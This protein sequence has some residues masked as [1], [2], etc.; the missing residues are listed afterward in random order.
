MKLNENGDFC[1]LYIEPSDE[2]HQ[3]L[4]TIGEQQKPVVLML[5]AAGQPR[6][7]LFQRP[8]DFS[9]LK[10]V[11]RQS[12]VSIV[13]VTAGSDLL[14]QMAAR[15]GFPSYPTIDDFADFLIHGRRAQ[16]EED[17]AKFPPAL[18]RVRT[19]PLMPSTAIAQLAA[20]RQPLNTRPL[21]ATR[22]ESDPWSTQKQPERKTSQPWTGHERSTPAE[23]RASEPWT[24]H[25]KSVPPQR[26]AR[27]ASTPWLSQEQA[28]MAGESW[29]ES[30][31]LSAQFNAA[32]ER[33]ESGD[34]AEI[35]NKL[36]EPPQ[37]SE[38]APEYAE[39][40]HEALTMP[41]NGQAGLAW[42]LPGDEISS[43]LSVQPSDKLR[44][45]PTG[46]GRGTGRVYGYQAPSPL[47][48]DAA[49]GEHAPA[50]RPAGNGQRRH[51]TPLSDEPHTHHPG[52]KAEEHM[53]DPSTALT[54]VYRP[55]SAPQPRSPQRPSRDLRD[56]APIALNM[57]APARPASAVPGTGSTRQQASIPG[58]AP[59]RPVDGANATR[60]A[61]M[62]RPA[63]TPPATRPP[64]KRGSI[65][66]LLVILSLL[67]ITGGALGSFV[68]IARV[69][70]SV[71]TT[72]HPVGSITFVSSEQ[73]NENTSQGIDDQVRMN[74]H[75]LGTPAPGKSYYAWLLGDSSQSESQ[76]ILLGK[77]NVS[78]GAASLFYA[79]D[80]LHTNLLQ[81][82][83][84]FLVTEENGDVMPLMPS[85]DTKT[86]RYYGT[87]PAVPDP[88]DA[89]HYSF[90]NHLR[91][92]LADEPSLDEL[93]LPGGLNNWFTR[94]TQ[95][96]MQLAS[97][98][99][100]R[101][102][103]GHDPQT[104]REL[105][106]QI[107]AYLDGMPFVVQDLPAT[108]RDVQLAQ[109]MHQAGIGL[110]D[111]RGSTQNPPGY[112]TQIVYHLNGLLNA[113]G[114]PGAAH[115]VV[116]QI[117][118][119]LSDVKTWLQKLRSDDKSLLAMTDVQLARPAALSLL[120]DMVLQA[121]NAYS[122][123]TDP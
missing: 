43:V 5:P 55:L 34:F 76:S 102:Q 103:N 62:T 73:L 50:P 83:S 1:L 64:Q 94:N 39:A 52:W 109:D 120:D 114:S 110:L 33:R 115:T 45:T 66:P 29:R 25:E 98:A 14:A 8:E 61:S 15:Y 56:Q 77:L 81:I 40:F 7:R 105:G 108:S 82:T 68:A 79:G 18:R 47:Q 89:H 27:E 17:E 92:L 3:L 53:F 44:Q 87:L 88:S 96:L 118:P 78:G 101:W 42:P 111:V 49:S 59:A 84:R 123:N 60:A 22:A 48:R 9:D 104:V 67:I 86:W 72:I 13:F 24:G 10:Y 20:L 28:E 65:W 117:L 38:L 95:E 119:S 6:S 2:K 107:L 26:E 35:I 100:D 58:N 116:N 37:R 12:G 46:D 16:H 112:V 93:E 75:S 30:S 69:A 31:E 54:Q 57:P 106:V 90:L 122:G 32:P 21:A 11:R 4:T 23:R 71:P 121:S 97:S 85:P 63:S 91:H 113:P 70:P 80:G 74:L 36:Q 19:G 51:S 99:R 41:I